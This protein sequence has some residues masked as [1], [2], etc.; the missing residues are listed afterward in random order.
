MNIEYNTETEVNKEQYQYLIKNFAGMIAH[1][2]SEGKFY[3][4]SADGLWD[5]SIE[6]MK[7]AIADA[8]KFELEQLKN[9]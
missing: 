8:K 4:N 2:E 5:M 7:N 1:R 6:G 9:A 3:G